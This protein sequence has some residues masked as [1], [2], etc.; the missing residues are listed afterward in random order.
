MEWEG[1][2]GTNTIC[3][4]VNGKIISVETILGMGAGGKWR[5]VNGVNSSV[6]YLVSC[7]YF[8]IATVYAAQQQKMDTNR[9]YW[10]YIVSHLNFC[11]NILLHNTNIWP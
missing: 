10:L 6:I 4:Y 11:V 7:K 3:F 9:K 5:I 1:K 8:V 2:Y